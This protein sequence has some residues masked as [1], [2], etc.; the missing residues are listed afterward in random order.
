MLLESGIPHDPPE[1]C[2]VLPVLSLAS[3]PDPGPAWGTTA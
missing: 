2:D 1:G 3:V